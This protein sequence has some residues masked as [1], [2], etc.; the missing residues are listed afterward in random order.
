MR[1]VVD[2]DLVA[3]KEGERFPAADISGLRIRL[4]DNTEQLAGRCP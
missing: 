2:Y 3:I 4:E 1:K